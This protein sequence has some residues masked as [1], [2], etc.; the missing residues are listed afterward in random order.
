MDLRYR[1]LILDHDDTAVDSTSVIHYP[2]H[3]EIMRQLRPK[4]EPV[5]LEEWFRKNFEPGIMGYLKTD[6]AFTPTEMELEFSIWREY[7]LKLIP[8]FYAGFINLLQEFKKKG[9]IVTVVSH[10]EVDIINTHYQSLGK[11]DGFSPDKIF[12]WSDDESKRK[13]SPYPVNQ[14][15]SKFGLQ[16]EEALIVD[17]LRPG[18]EMAKAAGVAV[19]AAGWAHQIPEIRSYMEENCQYYFTDIGNFR[20]F[21]LN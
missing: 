15:L 5:S 18:V 7:N 11:D 17:D 12:G 21:I 16:K 19:A 8:R 2:A 9:G 3:V 20:S 6:L 14:I 10:S 13:P 1:C 4:I